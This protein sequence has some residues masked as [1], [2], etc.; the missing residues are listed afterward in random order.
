[1]AV[2]PSK[3]IWMQG[4]MVAWEDARIHVLSHAVHYGSAVFEGIRCYQTRRGSA[5]FRL[6]EHIRRLL[7]SARIYR[8]PVPF[9]FDDL[10]AACVETVRANGFQA[11]YIRPLVYRGYGDVGVNPH[12]CPVEVAIATWSWGAYLGAE[13]AAQ[14]VDV[15]VSSWTRIAPNTL[16]ALAKT[17]ANYANSQLIKMEALA[18]G[19]VEGIALDSQGYV[20]EGSGENLFMVREGRVI[21]PPVGASVL[22]GITRDSIITLASDLGLVVTEARIPRE[23]LYIADE[24]FFTGTAAEI[25][26]IRSVDRVTVGGGTP[27]PVTT[28][29]EAAFRAILTGESPDR[30]GWLYPV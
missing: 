21:T 17:S 26:P 15:Q 19:Y 1:M 29:L 11:C 20:S 13:A 4:K 6:R 24:L 12:G 8:M 7:D 22:P 27:G 25:T 28:T 10:V 5:V 2:T 14:G 16:P 30:H 23:A 9:S 18:N 3:L